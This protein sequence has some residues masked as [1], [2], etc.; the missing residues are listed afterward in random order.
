[1]LLSTGQMAAA[2]PVVRHWLNREPDNTEARAYLDA[3]AEQPNLARSE[4]SIVQGSSPPSTEWH[5]MDPG[6]SSLDVI[7]PPI[8]VITQISS[9]GQ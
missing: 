8:P 6:T 5:R 3:L 1:V 4:P 7:P 9:W 2:E